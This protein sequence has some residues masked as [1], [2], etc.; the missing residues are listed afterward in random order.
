MNIRCCAT[1]WICKTTLWLFKDIIWLFK[2]IIWLFKVI[3][4]LFKAAGS[5]VYRRFLVDH[6]ADRMWREEESVPKRDRYDYG[7]S[8]G[9]HQGPR[10]HAGSD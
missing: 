9:N 1:I 5:P 7:G 3:I 2:D 4:W 10:S 8:R 6:G